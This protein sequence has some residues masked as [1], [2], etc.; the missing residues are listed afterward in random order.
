MSCYPNR[1]WKGYSSEQ[2]CKAFGLSL[3]GKDI[4]INNS[5]NITV[6]SENAGKTADVV[7]TDVNA[8]KILIIKYY[9]L[10]MII[11][12]LLKFGI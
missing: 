3:N 6:S 9:Y 2:Y 11:R 5:N 4:I 7:Q 1:G 10:L 12:N 8:S